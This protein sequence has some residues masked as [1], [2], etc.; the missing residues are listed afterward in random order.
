MKNVVALITLM[1]TFSYEIHAK[2]YIFEVYGESKLD[3]I[4]ISKNY[5]FSTYTSKGMWDDS[6]GDYGNENCTG[7]VKQLNDNVELE[8]YCETSNQNDET[9]WNS[10]IRKSDMSAGV[11]QMTILNAT[12][13]YKDFIGLT[14]PYGVNYKNQ[15][16]W[17]RAECILEK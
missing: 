2:E 16:A 6:E 14:C 3:T 1:F 5:K 4:K 12:G 7:Y 10:R 15:F 17:L 8:I 9:F 13:K 11:G